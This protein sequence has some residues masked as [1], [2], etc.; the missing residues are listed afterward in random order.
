MITLARKTGNKIPLFNNKDLLDNYS[1]LCHRE[2]VWIGLWSTHAL[3]SWANRLLSLPPSDGG[4]IGGSLDGQNWAPGSRLKS[5]F[6]FSEDFTPQSEGLIVT[7]WAIWFTSPPGSATLY[8]AGCVCG[9]GEGVRRMPLISGS[10]VRLHEAGGGVLPRVIS[11]GPLT[12]SAGSLV[13][14]ILLSSWTGLE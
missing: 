3:P 2:Q 7:I 12:S 5:G 14:L 6:L 4:T 8:C 9:G 11:P 1:F 10:S 13:S